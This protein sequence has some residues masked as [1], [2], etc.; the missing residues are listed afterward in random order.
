MKKRVIE[1][2]HGAIVRDEEEGVY[3]LGV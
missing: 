1:L 2:E 3:N